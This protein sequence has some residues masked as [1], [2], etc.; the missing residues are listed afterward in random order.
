MSSGSCLPR[1]RHAHPR[2]RGGDGQLPLHESAT[3]EIADLLIDLG[4]PILDDSL[5][6]SQVHG[7]AVRARRPAGGVSPPAR[8]RCYRRTSSR[9]VLGDAVLRACWRRIRRPSKLASTSL[10]THRCPPLHIYCWTL[11]FG[12][13]PHD[14][15]LKFRH[16]DVYDLLVS[17]QPR[18]MSAR[19]PT[20]NEITRR[21]RARAGVGVP[22]CTNH[23]WWLRL[24]RRAPTTVSSPRRAD[25]RSAS[26]VPS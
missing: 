21:P 24:A 17:S 3:V 9:H 12:L 13:S 8:A 6:R 16:R 4:T 15:A 1:P 5:H 23:A 11:G 20:H 18:L 26:A 10:A 14:V 2:V 22:R 25:R 19:R 7:R